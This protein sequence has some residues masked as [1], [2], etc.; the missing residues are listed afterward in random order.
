MILPLDKTRRDSELFQY[1]P[2]SLRADIA[3]NHILLKIAELFDFSYAVELVQ[4]FYCADNGR[5]AI[6]PEILLR[7]LLI[8]CIHN[9]TSFRQL[10][11]TSGRSRLGVSVFTDSREPGLPLVFIP[12]FRR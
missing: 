6:H 10:S 12:G 2:K 8:S 5:A 4:P 9:I 1:S 3:P 7:A 11:Q